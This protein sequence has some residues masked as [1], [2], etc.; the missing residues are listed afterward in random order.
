[1]G[2]PI[3]RRGLLQA[4]AAAPGLLPLLPGQSAAGPLRARAKAADG[5]MVGTMTEKAQDFASDIASR[6]GDTWESTRQGAQQ[7][8]SAVADSAQDAFFGVREFLAR[9]PF[10]TLCAGCC[11]GFLM[12][13]ACDM[14]SDS[15]RYNYNWRS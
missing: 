8:A 3:T 11:F 1:M 13:R 6:A 14:M 15:S 12:A 2:T 7:A 4:M 9:Y 5:W 10:A